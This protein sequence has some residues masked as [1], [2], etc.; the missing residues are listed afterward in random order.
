MGGGGGGGTQAGGGGNP[1][2]PPPLYTSLHICVPKYSAFHWN[3][4]HIFTL[5]S[6]ILFIGSC[7]QATTKISAS[8]ALRFELWIDYIDSRFP[9]I[10]PK[11]SLHL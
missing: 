10:V 11:Q 1:S 2:A 3:A 7:Y 4:L 8:M 9:N 6:P 5:L